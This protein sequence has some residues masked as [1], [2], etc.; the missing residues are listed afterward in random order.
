M[1]KWRTF[2]GYEIYRIL[3]G[4]SNVF[5]LTNGKANILIDTSVART[6][7]RIQKRLDS[8]CISTIDYLILTHTHFDHA[9]NA[10]RIKTKFKALVIVQKEEAAYLSKG[11]NILP[12][13]TTLITRPIAG[14]FGKRFLSGFKYEACEY[15]VLVDSNFDLREFGFNAYLLHTPGHTMGSMSLIIDNQI[16]IVGDTLFG[17]FKWSVFPPYAQDVEKMIQSWGK[18]LKT[19]CSVFIPSHGSENSRALVQKGYNKRFNR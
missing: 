17:V 6:W 12:K 11:E 18:L 10:K 15:D 14:I 4:R 16:A 5:L 13:G 2:S 3:S 8:L 1:K 19:N 7:D 9:A